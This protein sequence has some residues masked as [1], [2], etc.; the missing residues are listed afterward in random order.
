MRAAK[1][2]AAVTLTVLL[3]STPGS[4]LNVPDN[5]EPAPS[6]RSGGAISLLGSSGAIGIALV[7]QDRCSR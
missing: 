2:I 1:I 5:S 4:S 7:S 6:C 3:G